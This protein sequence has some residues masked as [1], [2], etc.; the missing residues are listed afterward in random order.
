M[1]LKKKASENFLF[2]CNDVMHASDQINITGKIA[3][4]TRRSSLKGR[5]NEEEDTRILF[6]FKRNNDT[7]RHYFRRQWTWLER[8]RYERSEYVSLI[9]LY[10]K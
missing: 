9:L 3:P 2:L 1:D 10:V 4:I 7:H 6:F 5:D 8:E